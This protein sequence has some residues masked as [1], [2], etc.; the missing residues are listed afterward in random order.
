MNRLLLAFFGML[1]MG[2]W[3]WG[4]QASAGDPNREIFPIPR[5]AN[6]QEVTVPMGTAVTLIADPAFAK[7]KVRMMA[8]DFS[9]YLT[10]RY[11]HPLPVAIADVPAAAGVTIRLLQLSNVKGALADQLFTPP[12]LPAR[13]PRGPRRAQSFIIRS[14]LTEKAPVIDVVSAS[15]QG[16]YYAVMAVAQLVRFEPGGSVPGYTVR[17]ADVLD[18]PAFEA[19][20]TGEPR[21]NEHA[22]VALQQ[23][24]IRFKAGLLR[25]T[26]GWNG[27]ESDPKS[28]HPYSLA[29]WLNV[30]G[31]YY[32]SGPDCQPPLTPYNWSDPDVVKKHAE[33][34]ASFAGRPGDGSVW[35][36][37]GTDAGWW[38][39]YLD[40]FWAKRDAVDRKNYPTDPTPARADAA[41]FAAMFQ[42]IRKASPQCDIFLTLPCYYDNPENDQLPRIGLFRDYLRTVGASVPASLK[43]RVWFILEE[44]SPASV[45]AY[46]KY[47]GTKVCNFR[48]SECWHG[49]SWETNYS[50]AKDLD[51]IADAFMFDE[52]N[53]LTFVVAA[54]Y[55]WNPDLPTD[56]AWIKEH[57]AP[58]AA[59]LLFGDAWKPM[60]D[61][62]LLNLN[63]QNLVR[64]RDLKQLLKEQDRVAQAER[65]LDAAGKRLPR[66]LSLSPRDRGRQQKRG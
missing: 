50:S 52:W 30:G 40:A 37:D 47:L 14:F 27:Q 25:S 39:F 59:R 63:G 3:G 54:Q 64:E 53:D 33:R 65:D 22:P 8:D 24:A 62:T 31:N 9:T 21:P 28:Q 32:A 38:H 42:A 55:L 49:S 61:F 11:G 34:A 17:G 12:Y 15:E 45:A 66:T 26:H 58:R 43:D 16:L 44:R 6:Y 46:Q 57:L 13:L 23:A 2:G 60:L 1:L 19:R 5:I 48:Y 10:E 7:D 41:R 35:W 51:G 20:V 36:H 18:W 29:R 56:E 4:G